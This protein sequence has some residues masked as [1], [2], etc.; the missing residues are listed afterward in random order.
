MATSSKK[1]RNR[2]DDDDDTD[3]E[4]EEW[5]PDS[6][7]LKVKSRTQLKRKQRELEQKRAKHHS[8][9]SQQHNQEKNNKQEGKRDDDHEDVQ[10]EE[11]RTTTT[12]ARKTNPTKPNTNLLQWKEDPAIT[13]LLSK[14]LSFSWS[15]TDCFATN[16][17]SS[18]ICTICNKVF[19][20]VFFFSFLFLVFFFV[21]YFFCFQT[22]GEAL[23]R[24]SC[25]LC[26]PR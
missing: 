23:H 19:F 14:P 24:S 22:I 3:P 18:I 2:A 15:C 5:T 17:P 13:L 8:T 21:L 7:T 12:T 1:K 4:A 16:K 10:A 9:T 20:S 26:R 6:P 25:P 11:Q